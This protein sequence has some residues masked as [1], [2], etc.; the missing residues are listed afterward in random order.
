MPPGS[1]L[2]YETDI[3]DQDEISEPSPDQLLHDSDHVA[4]IKVEVHCGIENGRGSG[5][6]IL[7]AEPTAQSQEV[8]MNAR[9]TL[10]TRYEAHF[11][12]RNPIDS[13]VGIQQSSITNRQSAPGALFRAKIL[14][15][16]LWSSIYVSALEVRQ[17]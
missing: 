5:E 15:I 16:V 17:Y 9:A 3:G 8:A 4:R 7:P 13:L 1:V 6:P 10:A 12:T 14:D 2:Q 11:G